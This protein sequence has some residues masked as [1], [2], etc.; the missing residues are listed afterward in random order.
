MRDIRDKC[1]S[2]ASLEG[3]LANS[4]GGTLGIARPR[5]LTVKG[6]HEKIRNGVVS[7]SA[8]SR[9]KG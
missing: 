6:R 4:I 9:S 8:Y 7:S 1:F 3:R 5:R 2:S